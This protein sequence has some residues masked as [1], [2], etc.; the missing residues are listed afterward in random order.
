LPKKKLYRDLEASYPGGFRADFMKAAG[1]FGMA[2]KSRAMI[3]D[4]Y[5][6]KPADTISLARVRRKSRP[7]LLAQADRAAKQ[8]IQI[9]VALAFF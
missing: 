6:Q 9:V 7:R 2:S 8:D 3:G 1:R 4:R 5:E